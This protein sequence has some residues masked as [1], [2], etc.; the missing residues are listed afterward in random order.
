MSSSH[1]IFII[2]VKKR[3]K[4]MNYLKNNNVE[5]LIHYPIA[6]FMQKAYN[7]EYNIK[8]FPTSIK[9]QNE[10]L[11]LPLGCILTKRNKII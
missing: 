4:L 7:F 10:A 1:H 6:P 3:N 8:N 2:F 5:T 11:S 9:F